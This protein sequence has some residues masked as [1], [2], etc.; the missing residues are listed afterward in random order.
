LN[1]NQIQAFGI[2]VNDNPF[3]T[4][5]E[6]GIQCNEAFIPCDMKGK[7]IYFESHVPTD[8]EIRHLPTIFITGNTWNPHEDHI[9]PSGSSRKSMEMQMVQWY[10]EKASTFIVLMRLRPLLNYMVRLSV[11]LKTYHL[12]TMFDLSANACLE[13]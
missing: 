11:N 1:P 4:D 13:M 9:Y 10:D 2:D 5:L 12:Y 7:V 6:L 8:W 3:D